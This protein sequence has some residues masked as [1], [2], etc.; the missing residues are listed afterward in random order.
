M[1]LQARQNVGEPQRCRAW[2]FMPP[3]MPERARFPP[4]ARR[5]KRAS[6]IVMTAE[7]SRFAEPDW[8][9]RLYNTS[10]FKQIAR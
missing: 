1:I 8:I 7:F 10:V 5:A 6:R 9:A 4:A 2:R 3:T